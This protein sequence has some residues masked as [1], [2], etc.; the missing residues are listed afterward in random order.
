MYRNWSEF[1]KKVFLHRER[2]WKLWKGQDCAVRHKMHFPRE[3]FW[4]RELIVNVLSRYDKVCETL[5]MVVHMTVVKVV[6]EYVLVYAISLR[7]K[8]QK[9]QF[10]GNFWKIPHKIYCVID[11]EKIAK[12]WLK[13]TYSSTA[14]T[15]VTLARRKSWRHMSHRIFVAPCAESSFHITTFTCLRWQQPENC[16]LS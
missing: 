14:L 2:H 6:E 1:S 9:R 13:N 10:L 16:F 8:F 4:A 3:Y 11:C 7:I 15:V 5:Q 12:R